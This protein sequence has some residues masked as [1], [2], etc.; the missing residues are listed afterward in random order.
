MEGLAVSIISHDDK[1]WLERSFK[2]DETFSA[3][4]DCVGDKAPGLEGFRFLLHSRGLGF[5]KKGLHLDALKVSSKGKI[6]QGD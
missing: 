6:E 1:I 5:H 4:S 3:L 2:E